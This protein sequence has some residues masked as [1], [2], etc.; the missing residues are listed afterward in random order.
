MIDRIIDIIRGFFFLM[1]KRRDIEI[2]ARQRIR[3]CANCEFRKRAKCTL[4]GCF[5][6]AKTRCVSETNDCPN[7][8]WGDNE[9]I[10]NIIKHK[11]KPS[12]FVFRYKRYVQAQDADMIEFIDGMYGQLYDIMYNDRTL[13]FT[14]YK[15]I[16]IGHVLYACR[17]L[18]RTTINIIMKDLENKFE[19]I[20][21]KFIY[22]QISKEREKRKRTT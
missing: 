19:G 11:S 3:E 6:P 9:E 20:R 14:K 15:E 22:E 21:I 8:Y 13:S 12:V 10:L 1:F 17:K 4:C 18:N 2:V 7:G 16:A 5:V